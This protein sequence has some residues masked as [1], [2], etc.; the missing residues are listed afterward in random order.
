MARRSHLGEFELLV[1]LTIRRLDG[2]A[3]GI[4][5]ANAIAVS[6]GRD[7]SMASLYLTLARLESHG[8]VTSRVGESTPERGG[9]VQTF[10]RVTAA[11]AR[12][13]RRTQRDLATLW[14]DVPLGGGHA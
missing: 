11:G 5:I 4:P 8:L 2:V 6:T 12:A 1:L 13:V 9:P 3:Y 10:F 7:V 14:S